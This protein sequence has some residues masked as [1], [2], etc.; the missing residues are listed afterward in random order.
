M[1]VKYGN[2]T[3]QLTGQDGNAFAIIANVA[4]ALRAE[5]GEDESHAYV[6][7]AYECP[8]YTDL[9]VLTQET[10]HVL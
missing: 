8:T 2:V 4:S 1:S 3:V 10:V 9:L 5:V 6:R 7:A